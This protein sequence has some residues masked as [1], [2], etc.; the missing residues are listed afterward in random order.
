MRCT[1]MEFVTDRYPE[2]SI[3]DCEH[4]RREAQRT[5]ITRGD[6]KLPKQL[7]KFL[8]NGKNKENLVD[9]LLVAWSRPDVKIPPGLDIY[10]CHREF[11]TLLQNVNDK[12]GY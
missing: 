5:E 12:C 7:Q 3:K 8:S 2:T 6:Q 10:L 11:C 4:R 9:F 1:R